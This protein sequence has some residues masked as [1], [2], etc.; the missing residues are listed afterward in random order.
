MAKI[1]VGRKE[2]I[3]VLDDCYRSN[4]AHFV[5]VYGTRRVGKTFLV[6]SHFEGAVYFLL[7]QDWPILHSKSKSP[8]SM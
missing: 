7:L 8:T 5:A 4:S 2:E 1:L 6:K 3:D